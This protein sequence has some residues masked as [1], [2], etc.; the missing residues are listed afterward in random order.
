[1]D[2]H[3]STRLAVGGSDF[4]LSKAGVAGDHNHGSIVGGVVMVKNF[5]VEDSLLSAASGQELEE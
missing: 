1:M 3:C 2:W 5:P 4:R